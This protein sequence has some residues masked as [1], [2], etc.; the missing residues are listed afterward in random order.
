MSAKVPAPA[1]PSLSRR[2]RTVLSP[3]IRT[4]MSGYAL[5]MIVPVA[6]AGFTARWYRGRNK[7]T[8][9]LQLSGFLEPMRPHR[10]VQPFSFWLIW[11]FVGDGE[12]RIGVMRIFRV[13]GDAAAEL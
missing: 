6:R 11:S 2:T 12:A 9:M 1:S 13:H 5:P 10:P 7:R 3:R 8:A 4:P